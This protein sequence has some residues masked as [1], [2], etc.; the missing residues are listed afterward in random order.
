MVVLNGD[1][2]RL[3]FS[4]KGVIKLLFYG[5]FTTFQFTLYT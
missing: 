1:K 5:K 4:V 3:L 2:T